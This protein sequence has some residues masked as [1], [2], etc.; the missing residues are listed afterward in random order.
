VHLGPAATALERKGVPTAVGQYN[1][2]VTQRNAQ[3]DAGAIVAPQPLTPEV[4]LSYGAQG[5]FAHK[6]IDR[7]RSIDALTPD[8]PIWEKPK[9]EVKKIS[10]DLT[11][12]G[13][14]IM[15][16]GDEIAQQDLALA[17]LFNEIYGAN[18]TKKPLSNHARD[19]IELIYPINAL[20]TL[21]NNFNSLGKGV[22]KI[23]AEMDLHYKLTARFDFASAA[24]IRRI[25]TCRDNT[26]RLAKEAASNTT[27]IMQ[28]LDKLGI[29]PAAAVLH[30]KKPAQYIDAHARKVKLGDL[31]PTPAF[32]W[33]INHAGKT[34]DRSR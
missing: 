24:R 27:S 5:K 18:T 23:Q 32:D 29:P 8:T 21:R 3:R 16:F 28:T 2:E 15:R 34:W 10:V 30:F 33:Y 19:A 22:Q 1:R 7:R 25:L 12:E 9:K 6:L 14:S 13:F 20:V 31:F 11:P 4:M 26:L 17:W